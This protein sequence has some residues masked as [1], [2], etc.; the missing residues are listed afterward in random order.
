MRIHVHI[1]IVNL[2][3]LLSSFFRSNN[4]PVDICYKYIYIYIYIY[5]YLVEVYRSCIQST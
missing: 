1:N 3:N 4:T 5:I 2:M